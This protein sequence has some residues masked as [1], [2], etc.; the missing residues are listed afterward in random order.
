V[1]KGEREDHLLRA[2]CAAFETVDLRHVVEMID[3]EFA[4]HVR[5]DDAKRPVVASVF[6]AAR[7]HGDD[8][9]VEAI[10]GAHAR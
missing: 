4:E 8:R 9:L 1:I 7:R 3:R 5:W 10:V 6:R 2:L